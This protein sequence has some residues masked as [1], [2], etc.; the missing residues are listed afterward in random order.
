MNKLIIALGML[1]IGINLAQAQT[2]DM[3][4]AD[5]VV[6]MD[7]ATCQAVALCATADDS[8]EAFLTSCDGPVRCPSEGYASDNEDSEEWVEVLG[9][10]TDLSA[11]WPL[12][13]DIDTMDL[14]WTAGAK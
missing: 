12:S 10:S 11:G 3:F 5:L 13:V 9:C 8:C 6:V 4:A 2:P 7:G 1:T 14:Y